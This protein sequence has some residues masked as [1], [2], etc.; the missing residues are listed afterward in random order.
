MEARKV[1]QQL[2]DKANELLEFNSKYSLEIG[3]KADFEKTLKKIVADSERVEITEKNILYKNSEWYKK[4]SR[5]D[6]EDATS[7]LLPLV[8]E[9]LDLYQRVKLARAKHIIYCNRGILPLLS[10]CAKAIADYLSKEKQLLHPQLNA[11][12]ANLLNVNPY[13]EIARRLNSKVD[14]LLIDEYQDTSPVHL[15]ILKSIEEELRATDK[16]II[17]LGDPKQAIFQFAGVDPLQM[18]RIIC[19]RVVRL[20][21]NYRSAS[22]IV[23]LVNSVLPRLRDTITLQDE[24][25]LQEVDQIFE[26]FEQNVVREA[27]GE[28]TYDAQDYESVETFYLE[29]ASKVKERIEAGAL[30]DDVAVLVRKK[31]EAETLGLFLKDAGVPYVTDSSFTLSSSL[32]VRTM[33]AAIKYIL[34]RQNILRKKEITT[35]L[36]RILSHELP[37]MHTG[38]LS[39]QVLQEYDMLAVDVEPLASNFIKLL[40]KILAHASP[41]V[42]GEELYY[43]ALLDLTLAYEEDERHTLPDYPAYYRS[44]LA[45]QAIKLNFEGKIKIVTIHKAKGLEYPILYLPLYSNRGRSDVFR[46]YNLRKLEIDYPVEE[47]YLK[48]SYLKNSLLDDVCKEE[49]E[50]SA[51]LALVNVLYVALTRARDELHIHAHQKGIGLY[52]V[53]K[54]FEATV[55]I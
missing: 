32:L 51:K 6:E 36:N 38:D 10:E 52:G 41:K 19:D 44:F 47:M 20:Q 46:M 2:K 28:V 53:L 16:R 29:L 54:A 34:D 30:P 5:T 40:Y 45:K 12:V 9:L 15:Q 42:K 48:K 50:G 27:K 23:E 17:Y 3:Q 1:Y 31:S 39:A 11:R 26:G 49:A 4:K 55:A 18:N 14:S 13:S 21:D 24:D 35:C 7:S 43:Y 33:V 22:S 25:Y 37:P 8:T